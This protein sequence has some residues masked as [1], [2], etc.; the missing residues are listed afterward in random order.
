MNIHK[1]NQFMYEV[2]MYHCMY[3]TFVNKPN[4]NQFVG[5]IQQGSCFLVGFCGKIELRDP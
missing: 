3:W 2:A 1:L 4:A 5:N